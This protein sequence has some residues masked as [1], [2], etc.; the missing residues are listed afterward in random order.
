MNVQG[1]KYFEVYVFLHNEVSLSPS[2]THKHTHR[3]Q[4][5]MLP[6]PPH[7]SPVPCSLT[8]A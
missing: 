1:E 2:F 4:A 3:P 6:H 7:M 5:T 8:A